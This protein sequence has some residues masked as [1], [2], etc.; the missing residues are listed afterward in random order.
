MIAANGLAR[1]HQRV[2][3]K[4]PGVERSE[5]LKKPTIAM[6]TPPGT[7][8]TPRWDEYNI[9][10]FCKA[11]SINDERIRS[12]TFRQLLYYNDT[13]LAQLADGDLSTQVGRIGNLN[14]IL[15]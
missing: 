11:E 14:C 7:T 9:S 5:A 1:T 2:A 6:D 10:K 3:P 8:K 13:E 4:R 12:T 15:D